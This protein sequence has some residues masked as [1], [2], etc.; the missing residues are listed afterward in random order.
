MLPTSTVR[1]TL[2]ASLAGCLFLAGA[3][4]ALAAA[5][6]PLSYDLPNGDGQA[7]GGT[8]NYWD[9]AYTGSG[10]S[11]TDRAA[12]SGGRG[13]LTDGVIS[14]QSWFIAENTDGTGPYVGWRDIDPTIVFHF[15]ETQRFTSITLYADDAH[16]FGGVFSPGGITIGGQTYTFADQAGA[17]PKAFTVD[18]LNL[19]GSDLAITVHQREVEGWVFLSEVTFQATAVPEPGEWAL[20][21]AGLAT[22]SAWQRARKQH[23]NRGA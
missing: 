15:G 10:S 20:M 5:V 17:Q 1:A 16:G 13:D 6:T 12:L 21:V 22:L 19:V 3:A 11:T 4:N 18:G 23:S 14:P 7:H 8:F 2:A 9:K